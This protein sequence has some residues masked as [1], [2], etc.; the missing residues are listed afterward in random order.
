MYKVMSFTDA[1]GEGLEYLATKHSIEFFNA[2]CNPK[3]IIDNIKTLATAMA[4]AQ[5]LTEDK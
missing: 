3:V 5:L 2:D 4:I 1:N